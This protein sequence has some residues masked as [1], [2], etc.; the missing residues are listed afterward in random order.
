MKSKLFLVLILL[1]ITINISGCWSKKELNE[2]AIIL[3]TGVDYTKDNKIQLT[4]QLA[5]PAAFGGGG[6]GGGAGGGAAMNQNITWVVSA[7]GDTIF[8]AQ[9]ELSQQIPR[10]LYLGHNVVLILDERL[11]RHGILDVIN[12]F[13][14]QPLSRG[15][16]WVMA[17]PQE[18]KKV[19]ESHSELQ[20]TSAQAVGFLARL[21]TGYVLRF[22]DL[23]QDLASRGSNLVLT[24]VELKR[25]GVA[26]GPGLE[27][28]HHHQEIVLTGAAIFKE[29]K[30]I[31]W[32]DCRE[33]QGLR[34]LKGDVRRI[35]ITIP[36]PMNPSKK[37]SLEVMKNKTEIK[38]VYQKGKI[39]F[40]LNIKTEIDVIEQQ[41]EEDFTRPEMIKTV[42]NIAAAEIRQQIKTTL[43]KIQGDYKVDSFGFGE[44][45][46]RKHKREWSKLKNH[47][48]EEFAGAQVYLTVKVKLR[49]TGMQGRRASIKK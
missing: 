27:K 9:R 34:W 33:T 38:P 25:Q 44:A 18:A 40:F 16:V 4:Y 26:Q 23:S 3:G 39:K 28:V 31:G 6:M 2:I 12:F 19:L 11:C 29:D 8:D 32:L 22:R 37:I 35:G 42:E 21:R 20:M 13:H 24:R 41:D 14:R 7:T 30:L 15:T 45:F 1:F 49:D 36:S 17:T 46:H 47:W 43:D 10:H 5:R 48:D